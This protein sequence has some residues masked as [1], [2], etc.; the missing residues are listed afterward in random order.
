MLIW[1]GLLGLSLSALT[2][3]GYYQY[4]HSHSFRSVCNLIYA[5]SHMAYIYKFSSYPISQKHTT[6]C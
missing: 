3:G 6:A 1:K 5:G 2:Y 4:Q